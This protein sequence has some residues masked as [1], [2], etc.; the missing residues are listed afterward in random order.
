MDPKVRV[1]RHDRQ[2]N[3]RDRYS[4]EETRTRI[5]AVTWEL[6]AERGSGLKLSEVGERA[7]VSRQAV[8][9]HFG[10][11]NGLLLALV[12]HMDE[13]LDLGA[14]LAHVQAASTGA[15][16]LE[17]AMRL[18]TDFWRAVCPVA[19]VLEAAKHDDEALA[20]A[21]RDRMEFRQM[22]FGMM[23]QR[24]SDQDELAAEWTVEDAAALLYAVAHFDTWRELIQELHWT[25]DHHVQAMTRLLQRSLLAA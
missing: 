14:S 1:V 19:Q 3:D 21:W 22:A 11:R 17:R 15:E 23:I 2:C 13:T 10:G 20:A 4:D 18:N 24:I 16:L 8:Y 7:G 12:S 5:L 6:V 9:L 25:D